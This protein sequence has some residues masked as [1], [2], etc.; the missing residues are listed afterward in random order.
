MYLSFYNFKKII[1]IDG[2]QKTETLYLK[3]TNISLLEA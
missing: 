1:E 2:T 3:L